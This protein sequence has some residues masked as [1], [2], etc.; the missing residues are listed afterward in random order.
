VT[1]RGVCGSTHRDGHFETLIANIVGPI[2][3]QIIL[4]NAQQILSNINVIP[5]L[6]PDSCANSVAYFYVV[7]MT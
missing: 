6:A 5:P 7:L 4:V 2:D 3:A 1:L